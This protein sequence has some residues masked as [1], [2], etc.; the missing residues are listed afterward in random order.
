MYSSVNLYKAE[1]RLIY[2][3]GAVDVSNGIEEFKMVIVEES[4]K[5]TNLQAD[6][7]VD[8]KL[9]FESIKLHI[10]YANGQSN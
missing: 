5:E 3:S 6:N 10:H 7:A 1:I 4:G 9:W 8:K 2:K